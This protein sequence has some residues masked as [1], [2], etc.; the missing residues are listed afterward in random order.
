MAGKPVPVE[1][2][3]AESVDAEPAQ[4][5]PADAPVGAAKPQGAGGAAEADLHKAAPGAGKRVPVESADAESAGAEAVQDG[6]AKPRGLG[7]LPRR[8]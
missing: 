1:S 3:D 8:T 4:A 7:A 5:T 6:A 2:A